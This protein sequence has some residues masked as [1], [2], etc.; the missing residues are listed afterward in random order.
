MAMRLLEDSNYKLGMVREIPAWMLPAGAVSDSSNMLYDIPGIARQRNATNALSALGAQTAY[1]TTL[2]FC[3]SQDG[4]STIEE[5]YA[6]EGKAFGNWDLVSKTTGATTALLT[7]GVGTVIYGRPCRHFGFVAFPGKLTSATIPRTSIAF[8]GATV[9]ETFTNTANTT[10]AAGNP[11]ITLSGAD[12]TTNN[13]VVGSIVTAGNATNQYIGRVTSLVTL[14][15]FTVW[16]IPTVAITA[17]A[18]NFTAQ[19]W[20]ADANG[21]ACCTSFQNR[22][23][24][25][26]TW[27]TAPITD[28]RRVHY[29]GLPTETIPVSTVTYSGAWFMQP[30]RWALN[31][32]DVPGTDPIVA[33]EPIDDNNLLILTTQG[34]ILFSGLLATQTVTTAPGITFDISPLNTNAGCLSDL[35]VQ[36]TPHG[37]IWASTEGVMLYAG[38]GKL[39]DLTDGLI[40]A[41]WR[42][43]TR[44][45]TFAIHGSAYF[46]GHYIVTGL[47][48]STTFALA[49]NL[50]NGSWAPLAAIDWFYGLNRPSN[51]SQAY[52]MR[53]WDQTAAAPSMTNGQVIRA[54]TIF[55]A[56]TGATK[57]DA[58]GNG[59][60]FSLTTRTLTDDAQTE[61]IVRRVSVRSQ[62]AMTAANVTV[63]AGAR[64]DPLD[65]TGTESV[66]LGSLSNTS[67]LTISGQSN[68]TPIVITT[69][70]NHGLQSEDWVDIH[71]CTPNT[72]ANGR[73]KIIVLS[74]TTFSLN[75]SSG[76][77]ATSATGDAKRVTE[78]E[79]VG[80][81]L[82]IG[83]GTWVKLDSAG[84]VNL[85][86]LHGVRVNALEITRGMGR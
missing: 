2:G 71:S 78:Q 47:S 61:R 66:T 52:V 80:T 67:V 57:L 7:G 41:Y 70:T 85:F 46:G 32:F 83:Q 9:N 12:V 59:V 17:T 24:Y 21:G 13:V 64:I 77:G 74:N 8:A 3:Y 39:V 73:W 79:Y 36:R 84:Q 40:N 68:A 33:M 42:S 22:L 60:A 35:S 62:S 28:D 23:L 10:V 50:D 65:T 49:Y 25:G 55:A 5:L 29:S 43:L 53:W 72:A 76:N 58:D 30:Y 27:T 38:G 54:D 14:T 1:G 37:I 19:I 81:T 20:T 44:N 4:A 26:N 86:Q 11:V 15:T 75:G 56:D 45:A 18:G 69:S 31:Y 48:G 51:P 82:D 34:V 63:S 6:G 16:P